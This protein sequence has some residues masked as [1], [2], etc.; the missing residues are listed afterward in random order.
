ML[1]AERTI[2]EVCLRINGGE[3]DIWLRV[4]G[5]PRW[6]AVEASMVR[7]FLRRAQWGDEIVLRAMSDGN[8][9]PYEPDEELE[10]ALRDNLRPVNRAPVDPET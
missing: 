9:E 4:N 7:D 6:F 3:L 1:T 2:G 8:A 5:R 10:M